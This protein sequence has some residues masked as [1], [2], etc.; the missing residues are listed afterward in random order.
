MEN[1]VREKSKKEH[2]C[3][4]CFINK[5]KTCLGLLIM[6]V[7]VLALVIILEFY[8]PGIYAR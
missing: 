7:L 8:I 3:R 1:R 6:G 2:K 5:L 4:N